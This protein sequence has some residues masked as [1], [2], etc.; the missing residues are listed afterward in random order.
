MII[1][2]QL[3]GRGTKVKFTTNAK[4]CVTIDGKE[5]KAADLKEGMAVKVTYFNYS[6]ASK[7]EANNP[8]AKTAG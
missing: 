3:L 8:T 1:R 2:P 4:T 5:A 6:L 7:V